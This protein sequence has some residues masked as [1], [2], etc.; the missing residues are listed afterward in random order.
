[1]NFEYVAGG[2]IIG[3]IIGIFL[4]AQIVKNMEQVH[5]PKDQIMW[6]L[7]DDRVYDLVERKK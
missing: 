1:M 3:F 5:K 4:V 7:V 2:A 6:V